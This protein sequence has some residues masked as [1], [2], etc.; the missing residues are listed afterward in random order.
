MILKKHHIC[1]LIKIWKLSSIFL[2]LLYFALHNEL[3][4]KDLFVCRMLCL[5]LGL[6]AFTKHNQ[7]SPNNSVTFPIL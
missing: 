4:I 6:K 1:K 5:V 3:Q 7:I 2:L